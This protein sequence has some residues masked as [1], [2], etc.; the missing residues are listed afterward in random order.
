MRSV[1]LYQNAALRKFCE[2]MGEKGRNFVKILPKTIGI[3]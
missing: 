1:F 2:I 3:L